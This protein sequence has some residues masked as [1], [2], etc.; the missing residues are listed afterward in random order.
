MDLTIIIPNYNTRHLLDRCL[1]SIGNISCEIIVVDNNS[2]DGSVEMVKTKYPYVTLI[3]NNENVG[4]GKANN[5]AIKRAK[6]KY[7]L[8]LN[9][10]C[11]VK[12]N[13]IQALLSCGENK[14]FVGGKL[15]NEDGTPQ[16][17]AGPFYTIPVVFIMLFLKGDQLHITRYS[18]QV[19]QEVDWVSGACLL[20]KKD[21]FE[22][23][24]LFDE[25][26][27]MYMEEIEFL[28]RAKK[29][30][31][32]VWFCPEATF[33]HTGAASSGNKREPV[34][35]IYRGLDYMYSRHYGRIQRV[36]LRLLLKVKAWFVIVICGIIGKRDIVDLYAKALTVLS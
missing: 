25:T 1:A 22:D 31:Y 27:F 20:G 11:I 9:S 33:I 21:A 24:G 3:R 6:G 12:N 19:L 5:M 16:Q 32:R 15:F 8:L 17:S 23:V 30:G 2:S 28:Y 13:A 36:L 18:P 34:V 29:K 7:I 26:I 4:Y 14:D 35:Q 10:D